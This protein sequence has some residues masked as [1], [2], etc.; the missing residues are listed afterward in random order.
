MEKMQRRS[1]ILLIP[2]LLAG[3]L[4]P[5]PGWSA[6][7]ALDAQTTI[8]TP[9]IASSNDGQALLD[10]ASSCRRED[11]E[12]L[13]SHKA[14]VHVGDPDG[15]TPLH[16]VAS[17]P[18]AKQLPACFE[19]VQILVEH[20]ADVNAQDKYG[21]T[22]LHLACDHWNKEIADFLIAHRAN[23]NLKDNWGLIPKDFPLDG[24]KVPGQ[25][26]GACTSKP[27]AYYPKEQLVQDIPDGFCELVSSFTTTLCGP[28]FCKTVLITQH[29]SGSSGGVIHQDMPVMISLET[30]KG[31]RVL[32]KFSANQTD[33][34][35]LNTSA[36]F[37]EIKQSYSYSTCG[38][39]EVHLYALSSNGELYEAPLDNPW[40]ACGAPV[41]K[42]DWEVC[43]ND[44][45][46][47]GIPSFP[48]V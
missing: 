20:G 19:V 41:E 28:G 16:R 3:F 11:I 33:V 37:I 18:V 7:R 15:R 26:D 6:D 43:D 44:K 48:L 24:K 36:N 1:G 8:E 40:D 21:R 31:F 35:I 9:I 42:D 12:A 5:L 39:Q 22:P 34:S 27:D 38:R 46:Q 14:D 2:F 32:E 45:V 17:F 47:V 13:L 25:W 30:E 29:L 4:R 10:A 23:P